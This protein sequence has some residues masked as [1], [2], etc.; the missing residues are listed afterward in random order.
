[1][2]VLVAGLLAL[3]AGIVV[4]VGVYPSYQQ[5]RS[6]VG[7]VAQALGAGQGCGGAAHGMA[8]AVGLGIL[9]LVLVIAGLA[10][11]PQG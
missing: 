4:G 6:V 9:G 3:V 1:M 10:Q 5:C 8:A 2:A 11:R 7:Q